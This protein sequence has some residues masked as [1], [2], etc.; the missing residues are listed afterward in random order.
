MAINF[1]ADKG[2]ALTY[3]EVDNNFGAYFTSA[4]ADG[5]TFTL[6]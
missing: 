3:S 5:N 2:Q 4:S 1:R 6:Y